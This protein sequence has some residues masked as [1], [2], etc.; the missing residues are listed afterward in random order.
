MLHLI[1]TAREVLGEDVI[2]FTTDG[3]DEVTIAIKV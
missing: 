2:L 1:S 3:G